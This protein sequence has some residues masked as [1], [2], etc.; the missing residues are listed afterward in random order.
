MFIITKA[1]AAARPVTVELIAMAI[2]RRRLTYIN[3]WWYQNCCIALTTTTK[4]ISCHNVAN[5]MNN[6]LNKR[7]KR[8][9]VHQF[10]A[11]GLIGLVLF[12]NCATFVSASSKNTI[13]SITDNYGNDSRHPNTNWFEFQR[14]TLNHG[15]Q[16][17]AQP[18]EFSNIFSQLGLFIQS[19]QR[20]ASELA[21]NI[22][23]KYYNT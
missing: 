14:K 17:Q 12:E 11:I 10:I 18:Q 20:N 19:R 23:F 4:M 5:Q 3:S 16:S 13:R 7:V 21:G 22:F 1:I 8:V 6:K 15:S 2:L 9:M